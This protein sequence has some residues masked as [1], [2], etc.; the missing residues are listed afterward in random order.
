MFSTFARSAATAQAIPSQTL[1][2]AAVTRAVLLRTVMLVPPIAY[3]SSDDTGRSGR[4]AQYDRGL[5]RFAG[6][7]AAGAQSLRQ[8]GQR[9]IQP[10]RP[11]ALAV[12][13]AGK[14]AALVVQPGVAL[15]VHH[16]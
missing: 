11:R 2:P 1:M 9:Y 12:I 8:K 13:R 3:N 10:C 6:R 5:M 14:D 4:R 15:V 16:Q 7:A